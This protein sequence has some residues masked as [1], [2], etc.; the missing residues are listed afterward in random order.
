MHSAVNT[1]CLEVGIVDTIGLFTDL[2]LCPH[3]AVVGHLEIQVL[4][5]RDGIA[6]VNHHI[7][8]TRGHIREI[9][10]I[11][12]R[13]LAVAALVVVLLEAGNVHLLSLHL[14]EDVLCNEA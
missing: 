7:T 13:V 1:C 6:T 9:F 11:G 5:V 3:G 4:I 12:I 8:L 14:G 10:L 2:N